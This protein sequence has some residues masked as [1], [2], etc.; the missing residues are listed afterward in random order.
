MS[1]E[2]PT[3]SRHA[4]RRGRYLL[5]EEKT[6]N[7]SVEIYLTVMFWMGILSV[8]IRAVWLVSDHPRQQKAVNIGTDVFSMIAAIVFLAWVSVLRF[9]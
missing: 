4:E 7:H 9:G 6:V 1:R 3:M 8:V 2:T 5:T